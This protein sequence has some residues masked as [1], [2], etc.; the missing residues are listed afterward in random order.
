MQRKTLSSL[1]YDD[2]ERC[3]AW[4]SVGDYA[5]AEDV[6]VQQIEWDEAGCVPES[7][8]EV[9]CLC[10]AVFADGTV[11]KACAMC[12][13]DSDDGPLLC[14]VHNG[15][16][17]VPLMLSPAPPEVLRKRGPSW[18][19]SRF[20]RSVEAVFPLVVEVV[21]CFARGPA[22]RSAAFKV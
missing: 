10:R 13:G 16:G 5:E 15:Y 4:L 20:D 1:S 9:W 2:L 12:R 22:K 18:F 11:H 17:D 7:V 6:E 8:G 14:S 3:T 21:P 19:A